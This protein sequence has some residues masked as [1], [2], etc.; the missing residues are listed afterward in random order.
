MLVVIL[1]DYLVVGFKVEDVNTVK[2]VV[3]LVVVLDVYIVL[4]F[5]VE[6]VDTIEV[7]Q[8]IP[9]EPP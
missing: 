5:K 3:V 7:V 8:H 6:D 4:G 1:D 2:V 9:A